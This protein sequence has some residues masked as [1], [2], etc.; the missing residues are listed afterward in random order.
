MDI[1]SIEGLFFRSDAELEGSSGG[2]LLPKGSS[3][4]IPGQSDRL[5]QLR[6]FL[7]LMGKQALRF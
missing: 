6:L 1:R 7:G 5:T 3:L 4:G 2:I